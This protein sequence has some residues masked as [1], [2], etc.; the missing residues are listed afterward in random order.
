MQKSLFRS[1]FSFGKSGSK[2]NDDST[3]VLPRNI[4]KHDNGLVTNR[5]APISQNGHFFEDARS[6]LS[7]EKCQY[8]VSQI[9]EVC[10]LSD[11]LF[12]RYYLPAIHSY[13]VLCQDIGASERYH[14][15]QRYGLIE[16][17]LEVAVY[18]MRKC[19]GS[20]YFPDRQIESIQWLERVFMYCV[21]IGGLLHDSGK[22]LT[23]VR[24]YI[25]AK[26]G[27]W[28]QWSPLIHV[29]PS[30]GERVEF[31]T[32]RNRN[33][34]NANVYLKH[35]HELF[36]TSFL[37]SVVPLQGLEWV[38]QYSEEYCAELF[39]HLI[40]TIASDY[41]NGSDIGA[42]VKA[43]DMLSTEDAVKAFH[44]NSGA[45]N[46]VDLEDPNLS[47]HE[48][49]NHVFRSIFENPSYYNLNCNQAAMGKFSHIERFGNLIFVSAKSVLPIANKYL[50]E[51]NVSI[52]NAQ[53]AYLLL[54][55]NGVTLNAPSGDTLWWVEFFSRNNNNK[56]REIS[57]L[58]FD[59]TKYKT[60][61]IEDVRSYGVEVNIS[62]KSLHADALNFEK[63]AYPEIYRLLHEVPFELKIK[64]KNAPTES[65]ESTE[66]TQIRDI[67]T[68][69]DQKSICPIP[70]LVNSE[71][72]TH[73]Q[74]R[75]KPP[76]MAMEK[77]TAVKIPSRSNGNNAESS[78]NVG[79]TVSADSDA[80][81][82]KSQGK[83]QSKAIDKKKAPSDYESLTDKGFAVALG[84]LSAGRTPKNQGVT[85]R[86]SV[87]VEPQ[88]SSSDGL[89]VE[90]RKV[91]ICFMPTDDNSAPD[92]TPFGPVKIVHLPKEIS[93]SD[94][95]LSRRSAKKMII[96]RPFW[97]SHLSTDLLGSPQVQ[98][99]SH[100]MVSMYIPYLEGL[101]ESQAISWNTPKSTVFMTKFGLFFKTPEF[102]D[103]FSDSI[104][105]AMLEVFSC[106]DYVL[107]LNGEKHL[108]SF[109]DLGSG[110]ILTGVLLAMNPPKVEGEFITNYPSLSL[111]EPV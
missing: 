52:P 67:S 68:D 4:E 37:S 16:H 62:D 57:Y 48:A 31:K 38:F 99:H 108:I 9:K 28:E 104:K 21:F 91:E 84:G 83:K 109:N 59:A 106:N 20:V 22:I 24:W 46:Y 43:A 51:K 76:V 42:S 25:K 111:I 44:Q 40:H 85:K 3:A 69:K 8:L 32:V 5:P 18:A 11:E 34:K 79:G 105:G 78:N 19:Q 53:S 2:K 60:V 100:L 47:I 103:L 6:I 77:R 70:P 96:G 17:S 55:D 82:R 102:F 75:S 30:E 39:I 45:T 66:S 63:E 33:K 107:A 58:V 81:Q 61:Q 92:E 90:D 65:T 95:E 12:E 101:F 89:K 64:Q 56:T 86:P 27:E 36:S 74:A 87:T 14:H 13:S 110:E 71:D 29:T 93:F 88:S 26:S 15:A 7:S 98:K 54:A 50:K 94:D 97:L 73:N 10:G 80:N 41:D 35:S 23:D 1:I 49:Y 72:L